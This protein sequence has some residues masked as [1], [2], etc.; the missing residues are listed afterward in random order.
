MH[1]YVDASLILIFI[2]ISIIYQVEA[3]IMVEDHEG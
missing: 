1:Y 2:I 3:C